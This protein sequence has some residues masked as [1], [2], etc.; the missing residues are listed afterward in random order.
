MEQT[1]D[2][3]SFEWNGKV[4]EFECTKCTPEDAIRLRV[5]IVAQAAKDFVFYF[6]P[7]RRK[8]DAARAIWET[9]R[10]LFFDDEYAI[11]FGDTEITAKQL[12]AEALGFD[13]LN[14]KTLERARERLIKQAKEYW[15]EKLDREASTRSKND[16]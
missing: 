1:P 11:M 10:D 3:R 8:G 7:S 16:H 15:R 12:I 13:E 14:Q 2:T 4:H 5:A 9:A 6:H